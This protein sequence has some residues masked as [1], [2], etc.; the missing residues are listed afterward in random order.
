[1]EVFVSGTDG[2]YRQSSKYQALNLF[3]FYNMFS[4]L[5]TIFFF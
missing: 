3:I 4:L 1:M 5:I 2:L